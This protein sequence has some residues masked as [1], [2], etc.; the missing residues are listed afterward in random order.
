MNDF[1]VIVDLGLS[2]CKFM[3]QLPTETMV[4]AVS[5][6]IRDEHGHHFVITDEGRSLACSTN[7]LRCLSKA[8]IVQYTPVSAQS[9]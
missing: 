9:D 7:A 6:L 4:Q 2:G 5:H 3:I 1:E 8:G